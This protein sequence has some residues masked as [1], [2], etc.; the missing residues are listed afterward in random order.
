MSKSNGK[1]TQQDIEIARLEEK[2]LAADNARCIAVKD[3][4]RRLEGMNEFR[5]QL[6]VQAETFIT[7]PELNTLEV[8]IMSEIKALKTRND[9][10]LWTLI[11]GTLMVIALNYIK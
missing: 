9:Y 11:L 5:E 1:N 7:K 4:E 10:I 6:R 2:L 8:R 3:L